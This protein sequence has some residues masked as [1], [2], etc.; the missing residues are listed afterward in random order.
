MHPPVSHASILDF[1]VEAAWLAGKATLRHFQTG[2]AA[3]WKPDHSPVTIADREAE[4]IL[5]ARIERSFPDDGII[6]EEMGSVRPQALRRWILDPID[7]TRSFLRGVPLYGVLIGVEEGEVTG[8]GAEVIA[9][10]IHFPALGETVAAARGRGCWWNGRPCRVSEVSRIEEAA[11]LLTDSAR[12]PDDPGESGAR[13][14]G[15]SALAR[16]AGLTR[17]WGDCYGHALVA[18]GRAEAMIDPL[19][20]IWDCAALLPVIEEAGGIF[21]DLAGNRTIRGQSAISTN[22]I[23]GSELRR[24]LRVES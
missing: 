23:L 14:A 13:P 24:K 11:V 3:E 20:S 2:I 17:T 9:G 7:G 19:M 1:A 22:A 12:P 4:Q 21:T 5:R 6:G 10:V 18:T 16:Q 15:W 8:G